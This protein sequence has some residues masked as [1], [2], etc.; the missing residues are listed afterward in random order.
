MLSWIFQ[1]TFISII[2]IFLVHHLI[3]FFKDTLTIPKIKDLVNSPTKKYEN[4]FLTMKQGNMNY[5]TESYVKYDE[6]YKK[7]LL[8][9]SGDSSGSASEVEF[10]VTSMKDELKD[11][12]KSQTGLA[13]S[14]SSQI[15]DLDLNFINSTQSTN[16]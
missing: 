1:I 8:P 16:W 5:E 9:M 13:V 10:D 7:S 12:L 3:D 6:S 4:M 15:S 11:Y 14:G 2:L